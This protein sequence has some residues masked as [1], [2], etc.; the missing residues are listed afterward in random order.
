MSE[1]GRKGNSRCIM[2]PVDRSAFVYPILGIG[3]L[4]AAVTSEILVKPHAADHR[5]HI[6][7]WE[8]WTGFEFDAMK[9]VV[10]E[11][12]Q[13]Q[14]KI[15]VDFLSV[16][17][18]RDK[19]L[20]AISGGVPPDLAGLESGFVAQFVDEKALF[21]L[22]DL[23]AKGGISK[24][25]YVKAYWDICNYKGHT[26]ALP[27][28]PASTALHY[29]RALLKKAGFNPDKP[30]VTLEELSAM[31]EKLTKKNAKG[32]IT[33]AGFLPA[34]PGWWN[35]AWG[36]VYGGKLWDGTSKITSDSKE[37]V[38]GFEFV[39][40]FSKKYGPGQI[41][42]FKSGFGQFSSPQNAFM[43]S[44]VVLELQGVW[45]YN[46]IHMYKP[47]LDWAAAP[48]PYPAS[49]P[50]LKR[51]TFV[52]EDI[53]C[54]PRG[55]KHIP[56]AFEF[57]K[58]VQSQHGMELL[59]MGQKKQTPLKYVTPEFLAKHPNPYIKLFIA[60]AQEPNAVTAPQMGIW[61]E[62]QD[63]LNNAY[64]AISLL[65]LS[66]AEALKKVRLRMQP[67]LDHYLERLKRRDAQEQASQK[68]LAASRS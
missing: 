51:M 28:T 41:Q 42:T 32:S 44:Q 1:L 24:D 14:D 13:S 60:M 3:L 54:I 58:F 9:A 33:V 19:T 48:F 17:N 7:Y 34:E 23:C 35:W 21:P 6:T 15:T 59:C 63:E 8:K 39:Q 5:V 65:H 57:A 45:M 31:A 22:D 64:D 53:L 18:I 67:K 10:D 12:N 27:T 11:F 30:P 47:N 56:E 38:Q 37:N 66:P 50:D 29:N 36:C 20:L 55:A 49:R 46:F 62:Y 52:D 4:A 26:Y 61:P 2:R 68:T 40:S 43:S 16:S 25:R